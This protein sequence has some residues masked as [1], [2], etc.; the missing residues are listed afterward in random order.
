MYVDVL[1]VENF[2]INFL[3][4]NITSRFSKIKTTRGKLIIGSAFGALYVLIVFFPSLKIFFT[5]SMKIAVS[6][7]MIII[8]FTPEKFRE[9][10]K[11]LSIFYIISFAFG[12]AAFSLF[13]FIGDGNVLNGVFYIKDFPLSLL[14]T[15]FAL[16]Y[17]LLTFCFG[18]IHKKILNEGLI[19]D[20]TIE[21]DCKKAELC[22]I[23]DT[24][25]NLKDPISDFPVIVAEY[26]AIKEILPHELSVI[27]ND[28]R[29]EIDFQQLY[30]TLGNTDL[31]VRIRLIPFSS[32][33]KENGMLVGIKP[34]IVKLKGKKH[35]KEV[36]D[37]IIGVYKK[38]ISQNGEYKA[39]LYPEIFN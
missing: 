33:G 22:A 6:I 12:G 35:N 9:F 24:G 32:L 3:I 15:A 38:R 11:V 20:V 4:L 1:L 27:F 39:L 13:Y 36:K 5:L 31:I 19:F 25:N 29:N 21:I 26:G 23:L 34:D 18:Y 10:F 17:M 2:I 30:N 14:I 37:V 8:V 28:D 7:L 16:G